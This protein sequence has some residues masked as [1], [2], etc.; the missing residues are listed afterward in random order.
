MIINFKT[1]R[2]I[3][4]SALFSPENVC[5]FLHFWWL[6]WLRFYNNCHHRFIVDWLITYC[7]STFYIWQ[8]ITITVCI[9]VTAIPTSQRLSDVWR[10][11]GRNITSLVLQIWII[12]LSS[13]ITMTHAGLELPDRKACFGS[14][15]TGAK[16]KHLLCN[17]H[18]P[19]S[20]V[21]IK[22]YIEWMEQQWFWFC[23]FTCSDNRPLDWLPHSMGW[24]WTL[25]C[26]VSNYSQTS[27]QTYRLSLEHEIYRALLQY[28]RPLQCLGS[29]RFCI[30]ASINWTEWWMVHPSNDMMMMMITAEPRQPVSTSTFSCSLPS[31][32][33]SGQIF[34]F[35]AH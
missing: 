23:S 5:Y 24:K 15:C 14:D 31:A 34:S 17:C 20:A 29:L 11:D 18:M 12:H 19:S 25:H 16:R 1:G 4:S 7:F 30:A 28:K 21:Q 22:L 26:T 32:N 13:Y 2:L 35:P 9:T 3:K 8:W 33:V 10:F 27:A 6:K